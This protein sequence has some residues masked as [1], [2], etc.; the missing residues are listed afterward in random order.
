[1]FKET[2]K[3]TFRD[4]ENMNFT[5]LKFH[6]QDHIEEEPD[7]GYLSWLDA[8]CYEN[9]NFKIKTYRIM[10]PMRRSN[11]IEEAPI[12]ASE[13]SSK[14]DSQALRQ[15]GSPKHSLQQS[16]SRLRLDTI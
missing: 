1:M 15:S 10:T 3:N 5:I 11:T 7:F 13:C 12:V 9:F 4:W 14:K 2:A 8:P 16:G 6:M